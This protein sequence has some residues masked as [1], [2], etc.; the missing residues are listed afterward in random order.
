M[1]FS[2]SLFAQEYYGE[3]VVAVDLEEELSDQFDEYDVFE[4]DL[5]AI[6]T[7]REKNL[8]YMELNLKLGD[9]YNWPLVLELNDLRAKNYTAYKLV[10]K[11]KVPIK[12]NI[13]RTYKGFLDN[14]ANSELRLNFEDNGL[15]GYVAIDG[16]R[17]IVESFS[18]AENNTKKIKLVVS[19]VIN[20]SLEE[21]SCGM[22][23][24]GEEPHEHQ[25]LLDNIDKSVRNLEKS[26]APLPCRVLEI[27]TAVSYGRFRDETYNHTNINNASDVNNHIL[28]ILNITEGYYDGTFNIQF[29]VV[30]QYVDV[31]HDNYPSWS[32]GWYDSHEDDYVN[33]CPNANIPV[34]SSTPEW[35]EIPN[36]D[37]A[38]LFQT[39]AYGTNGFQNHCDVACLYSFHN[40]PVDGYGPWAIGND[41]Y[42]NARPVS[43]MDRARNGYTYYN[44][45]QG[46]CYTFS[47]ASLDYLG[48][49][50]AHE[51]GHNFTAQH[52][53]NSIMQGSGVG[54]TWASASI[55]WITDFLNGEIVGRMT[56]LAPCDDYCFED[57]IL[58]RPSIN[59]NQFDIVYPH[60]TMDYNASSTISSTQQIIYNSTRITYTAGNSICLMPGFETKDGGFMETFIDDCI[61][62]PLT[63]GET[64]NF[65]NQEDTD[66]IQL[67]ESQAQNLILNN[68]GLKNYP[69]PFTGTTTIEFSLTHQSK[70]S[71][72][73]YDLTG[74]QVKVLLQDRPK[75]EGVHLMELD[76]TDLVNGTYIYT[77]KSD[78]HIESKKMT[79]LK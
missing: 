12:S 51:L 48:R 5:Q 10:G 27:A 49:L 69:N 13:P 24:H 46:S 47:G 14:E 3:K 54:T 77:L 16:N 22:H 2:S 26:N 78:N 72:I 60:E 41:Y 73:I 74:K 37:Y 58:D 52:V 40:I 71:L 45:Y 79:I 15:S 53:N 76:A 23:H 55:N 32:T 30:N 20:E 70:V 44:T 25:E 31:T 59:G 42:S 67:Q 50:T 35:G 65:V 33:N 43:I 66:N 62:S 8:N 21:I 28:S 63:S 11:E 19:N 36:A 68:S 75:E 64:Y 56:C 61:P 4:L 6:N 39:W 34:T 17:Y 7:Y 1:L 38:S 57:Y 18:D 9:K 29:E